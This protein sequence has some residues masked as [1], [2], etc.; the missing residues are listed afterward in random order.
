MVEHKTNSGQRID[1]RL[2]GHHIMITGSTGFLAKVFVEKLIRCVD[3]LAGIHLLVRLKSDGTSAIDRVTQEVFGSSVFDRLRAAMGDGFIQLCKEKIHVVEGDL[4]RDHLGM[5]QN[6]YDALTKKITLIVNSAATVTFDERID[7]AIRLNSLG[8]GRLLQFAKDSGDI[9]F[10][11]VSTSYVSGVRKGNVMEDFSAPERAQESLPRLEKNGAFDFDQ[12]I[13]SLQTEAAEIRHRFAADQEACRRHLID[14]GMD[15]ARTYGWN[16]TYTFTKWIGEQLLIRDRGSVPLVVFRPAIIEGSFDEPTPGWIDGLRMADPVIVAYGRGKINEFPVDPSLSIDLIPVDFVAN[17]M[18]ATLPVGSER[19][20]GVSVYHCGSSERNPLRMRVMRRALELAYR[21]R[22]MIDDQGRPIRPGKLRMI[23]RDVFLKRWQRKHRRT[24]WLQG[25]MSRL[26]IS[27]RWT[28][29]LSGLARQIE[30]LIYFAKIYSPYTH[31]DCR[32]VDDALQSAKNRLHLDDRDLYSFD[33]E[34]IDWDDYI[35]NRHVPG[36]RNYV[37]G[38]GSE[39]TGRI[40]AMENVYHS[41]QATATETLQA[42]NL[43]EVF[44]RSA[45]CFRDKP[46]FQIRRNHRWIRYTYDESLNAT[47]T[48][49][50][51]FLERGLKPGDRVALCA[52]SSP[53]WGLTY[54]T[55]MRAGLTAIPLD[56]QLPPLEAW[57]AARFA[58]AKLMCTDPAAWD[59]LEKHRNDDDPEMVLIR[60]PFVPKPG[61]SRDQLPDPVPVQESS[62][63]SI[64]FTSGTTVS[65]KAVQLS[66]RNFISDAR[67]LV[68]VHRISPTDELLSVLPMYHAFEFTGGFLI[69][70][71]SG[72]TLTYVDQFKGKE[73]IS[74]MQATGTTVMLVVPRLLRMFYDSIETRIAQTGAIRRNIFRI[75]GLLSRLTGGLFARVFFYVVHKKFGGC[76]RMFVCGG[77]RLD[78]ELYDVFRNMG[79]EVYEGYGLTETAPVLTVN[80]PNQSRRSSVGPPLPNVELELRNENLEGIGEIWVKGP[81]VMSG[82]LN[83]PEATAKVLEGDWFRTGDLGRLD[84]DGFLYLTGRSTDLIVTSAGKNV[85]P[86][87]VEVHYRDLPYTKEL[88]AFGMAS[89]DNMGEAVHAVVVMDREIAPEID[90]SSLEREIRLAAA[91]IS[92]TLPPHQRISNLHFWDQELPKTSTLKAKRGMIR[93]IIST[94]GATRASH[95]T[96]STEKSTQTESVVA[97]QEVTIN[98]E[99]FEAIRRILAS[100]TRLQEDAIEP[101]M[102]LQLDLGIDSIGKID[103]LGS[104]E[105][106]FVMYIDDESAANISRVRDLLRLIGD[107]KP[108]RDI[109]RKLDT[110]KRRLG[111]DVDAQKTNGHLPA[112]LAPMRW[113]VRSTVNV[114]MNTYVRVHVYGKD[115]LPETGA[116]ILAPNHSSHLD[117]PSVITAI[118]GTRRVWV[119]GAEDYFFNTRIK[120]LIFGKFLDTIAFD[121]HADGLTGLRKCGQALSRGDGLIIFPEGTRSISGELQTFKIGIAVLSMERNVPIIPVYIDR[122]YD[123]LPKGRHIARPGTIS[124]IFGQPIDPPSADSVSNHYEAFKTLTKQVEDAVSKLADEVKV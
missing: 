63:A 78:P 107:R 28:R 122:S 61:A 66:H 31:L 111:S 69:P 77:S 33:V 79:F 6:D 41:E 12:L 97:A 1:D 106:R 83:N 44:R 25:L 85:Y 114:I 50:Q 58:N 103:A 91:N 37:L 121:R 88:C 67:A 49:M 75:F 93:E 17:A 109:P 9:P 14:M 52:Q 38:K 4:T 30:Q 32:F 71:A 20:D 115:N 51:R 72:A 2:A 95:H 29:K 64:L 16:D 120:R 102:H 82:Y 101:D 19:C 55:M 81:I 24:V 68:N 96:Q 23:H 3:S 39:P 112:P 5:D 110:W 90:R 104:V 35:I 34:R 48:M 26:S 99:A 36:L 13:E 74:A 27:R 92:E 60:E 57:S 86:D 54:L 21:K 40:R 56:P 8:P 84:S 43:F 113:L 59:G 46:A 100:Q 42:T 76:L 22:P 118:G 53:E 123:L 105:A 47:G 80:P 87:E 62:L 108:I 117:T 116:F 7:L 10:M 119:A 94:E 45:K 124:V 11:H 98:E 65:P 15:R 18:I 70:L 73:I 89:S